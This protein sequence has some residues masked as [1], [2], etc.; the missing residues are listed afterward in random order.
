M[1]RRK[2]AEAAQSEE[3]RNVTRRPGGTIGPV[4]V[5]LA[6]TASLTVAIVHDISV[7][8]IGLV[9]EEEVPLGTSITIQAMKGSRRI[10][11]DVRHVRMLP[12]GHLLFG[13]EFCHA[14]TMEDVLSLG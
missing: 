9:P 13:C 5:E 7:Q 2:D 12:N 10:R 14:L 6:F 1:E 4:L 8:G 3:R 11:A